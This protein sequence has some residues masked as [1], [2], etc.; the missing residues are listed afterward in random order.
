[1]K[2][3][4][5]ITIT[6]CLFAIAISGCKKPTTLQI[7]NT[8]GMR[9]KF[10]HAAPGVPALDAYVN[11]VQIT[12]TISQSVTDNGATTT[13]T[14]TTGYY[15]KSGFPG[16][17]YAV[18][19]SG[20][21]NIKVVASQPVPAL[22]SPQTIIPGTVVSNNTI[23]TVDSSAYSI[24]TT[25]L[26]GSTTSPLTSL[27]VKDVFPAPATGMS[28]IRFAN[29]IPNI[30]NTVYATASYTATGNTAATVTTPITGVAYGTVS[31]F[32]AVP[33]NA[34]STTTYVYQT[35]NTGT[36]TTIASTASIVMTAGRYYTLVLY[37]LTA[38]YSVPGTS[39]TL[40][41][42][43]RPTTPAADPTIHYPEIYFNVPGLTYYTNK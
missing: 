17:T 22:L 38:D 28:Y 4:F 6:A 23:N 9:I 29:L 43:A 37:G 25:G 11:G 12:P 39:I 32:V 14:I 31:S 20:S 3:I 5:Y 15:Y 21:V 10:F 8:G 42:T 36:N 30:A 27:V 33:V 40:K 13:S 34:V 18:V 24:I 7:Y 2:K 41:A 35:Y 26:P 16:S 19:P 1:M